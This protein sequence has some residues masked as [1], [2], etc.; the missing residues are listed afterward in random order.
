MPVCRLGDIIDD[1]CS[2]CHMLTN[3][4]VE[5]MMGDSVVKVR[6]RTC[7][8]SHNYRQGKAPE[9]KKPRKTSKQSAYE[10]VLASVLAGK[11]LEAAEPAKHPAR[12]PRSPGRSN[13]FTLSRSRTKTNGGLGRKD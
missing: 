7:N 9:G 11:N 12:P 6:C 8:Y 1:Y 3:N 2:R 13:L 10:Q 5:A 4:A